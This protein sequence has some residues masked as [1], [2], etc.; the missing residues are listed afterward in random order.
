M[1]VHRA[2]DVAGQVSA[3]N[4][5]MQDL[6]DQTSADPVGHRDRKRAE[7]Y[8]RIQTAAI[9]LFFA[10]G[11]DATT[12]DHIAA[13]AGVSRRSLFHYFGS[14]ED[15][16]FST[17]AGLG[18]MIAQAVAR[19]P[20]DEPLLTMAENALTDMAANWQGPGPRALAR[21]VH[22]TPA[23]RAGDHAKYAALEQTLASSLAQRKGLSAS[24]EPVRVA[25]LASIAILRHA[26]EQ[27]L[28]ADDGRG[29]EV[30]GRAAFL[31]LRSL[32]RD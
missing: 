20:V 27:W 32:A 28:A 8:A 24:D 9:R 12:L 25:S 17:K 4:A 19:R 1:R 13:E 18:E 22:D 29:P 31:A 23:L 5:I 21:L 11:F 26:T 30:F 15:I 3:L 16:V 7:T 10:Q 2:D 14:K 6:N